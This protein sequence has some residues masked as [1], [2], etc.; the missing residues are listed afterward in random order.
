MNLRYMMQWKKVSVELSMPL[1]YIRSIANRAEGGFNIDGS[2]FYLGISDVPSLS[3]SF[4]FVFSS[5]T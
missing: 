4:I 2:I 1:G 3:L 5:F